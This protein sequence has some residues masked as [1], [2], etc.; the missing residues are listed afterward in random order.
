MGR[1]EEW[2]KNIQIYGIYLDNEK[3]ELTYRTN[4]L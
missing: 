2:N 1:I 4:V 3:V